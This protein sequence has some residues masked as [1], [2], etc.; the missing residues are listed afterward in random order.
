MLQSGDFDII[1][2]TPNILCCSMDE[3]EEHLSYSLSIEVVIKAAKY[4]FNNAVDV[5]DSNMW[6]A[7]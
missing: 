2:H 1:S 4:Y 5:D 6:L 3:P 7:K